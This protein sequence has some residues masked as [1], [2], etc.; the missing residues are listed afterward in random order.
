VAQRFQRCDHRP[1]PQNLVIPNRAKPDEESAFLPTPP[2]TGVSGPESQRA[3]AV[4]DEPMHHRGRAALQRRVQAT[5]YNRASAPVGTALHARLGGGTAKP[6]EESYPSKILAAA[7]P[8]RTKP[9][10]WRENRVRSDQILA[11][12]RKESG[13]AR[14]GCLSESLQTRR[15]THR[16][17]HVGDTVSERVSY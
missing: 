14:L 2:R 8:G 11:S 10:S 6:D 9:Q 17:G 15:E 7:R 13:E 16:W 12:S 1:L 5:K 3:A 4:A